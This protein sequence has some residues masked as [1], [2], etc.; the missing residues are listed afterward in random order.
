MNYDKNEP[1]TIQKLF[2]SIAE[3]YDRTNS[4]L[5]FNL[6]HYWNKRL[7][8]FVSQKQPEKALDLCCGT[9]EIG[10]GIVR[11]NLCETTFLDFC[12]EMLECAKKKGK[13]LPSD[14]LRFVQ[15]DA[16]ETKLE[17]EQF[18]SITI[19]YGIRNV[20]SPEKCIKEAMRLLKPQGTF[21]ILELTRPNNLL[22][23]GG[24]NAYLKWVLPF[25]GKCSTQN[26][27]AYK[28]LCESIQEF[29]DPETLKAMM[30]ESGFTK[31]T[32][33]PLTGG[34]ATIISGTKH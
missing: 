21:A 15:G 6:Q 32:V 7:V 20:Q 30:L 12:P 24:H 2:G 27:E 1:E 22:L 33:R 18:D 5:S 13:A 19:A 34:I 31:T 8:N 9:G 3:K 29:V 10:F 16:Q 17:A 26:K 28:Y 4:I 11:K 14:K 23:R 25:L